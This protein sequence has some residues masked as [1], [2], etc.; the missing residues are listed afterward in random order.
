MLARGLARRHEFTVQV[1][2][3]APRWRVARQLF[4]ESGLLSLLGT[5]VALILAPMAGH[6][7][8]SQVSTSSN[9]VVL[10]LS[11]DWRT[12]GFALGLLVMT[13]MLFGLVPALRAREIAPIDALKGS[14][15][16]GARL[17]RLPNVM[18]IAQ[19]AL[20]LMLVAGAGL[21]TRT[22]E[23][24]AATSVGFDKEHVLA[25][26]VTAPTTPA[27]DRNLFYH[28]LVVAASA[29]P[30][31]KQAG[32][33][34]APPPLFPPAP[35]QI[36]VRVPGAET[37]R[38]PNLFSRS[39]FVTPGW[40]ESLGTPLLAGRSINDHETLNSPPVMIVNEAFV[41]RFFP[42]GNALGAS[43]HLFF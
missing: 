11:L 21:L 6:A 32:G 10:N 39:N 1:A 22:F 16:I 15:R 18:V 8:V 27:A 13:T 42:T 23:S 4:F 34:L 20:S 33:A 17:G 26:T 5:G 30:G 35:D 14:G 3:G 2:L 31:V 12:A 7:I 41:R 43:V 37:R 9:P 40:L 29:A 36:L 24:L 19:V 28:Q 38:D 25:I